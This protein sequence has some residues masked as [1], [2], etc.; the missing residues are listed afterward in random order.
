MPP[1]TVAECSSRRS[2]S[3]DQYLVPQ[4]IDT[5]EFDHAVCRELGGVLRHRLRPVKLCGRDQLFRGGLGVKW[6]VG[7]LRDLFAGCNSPLE[8]LCWTSRIC[9]FPLIS[10]C[11]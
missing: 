5:V 8:R 7:E 10:K 4:Q 3:P 2:V 11:R 6:T 1:G 9:P